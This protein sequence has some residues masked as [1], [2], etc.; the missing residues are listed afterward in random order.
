[1]SEGAGS[2][3]S[4]VWGARVRNKRLGS[5]VLGDDGVCL[6]Q[7]IFRNQVL[8][9][10]RKMRN[11]SIGIPLKGISIPVFSGGFAGIYPVE[12]SVSAAKCVI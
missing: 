11:R 7:R 10:K 3:K 6:C 2:A 12:S 8:V 9:E 1:M 4:E 5:G